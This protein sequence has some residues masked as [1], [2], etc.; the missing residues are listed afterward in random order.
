VVSELYE[1]SPD[2]PPSPPAFQS[3]WLSDPEG[4]LASLDLP[5]SCGDRSA[6]QRRG[7]FDLKQSQPRLK[8][9]GRAAAVASL[10]SST[11][12]HVHAPPSVG[13]GQRQANNHRSVTKP[14]DVKKRSNSIRIRSGRALVEKSGSVYRAVFA[15]NDAVAT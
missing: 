2:S 7:S 1:D 14:R 11:G 9:R 4:Q 12:L 8:A 15:D 13:V 3:G 5:S 10:L 6:V